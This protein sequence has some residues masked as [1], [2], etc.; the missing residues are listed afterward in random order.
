MGSVSLKLMLLFS[1]CVWVC[2]KG[3]HPGS[4]MLTHSPSEPELIWIPL[5]ASTS[6]GS[7]IIAATT[8]APSRLRLIGPA[9]TVAPRLV[10]EPWRDASSD[11]TTSLPS[12]LLQTLL[13]I[14]FMLWILIYRNVDRARAAWRNRDAH[15]PSRAARRGIGTGT[16]QED[17]TGALA[18]RPGAAGISPA[19]EPDNPARRATAVA[20][21]GEKTSL[22]SVSPCE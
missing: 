15:P 2:V 7:P 17:R 20:R 22:S 1:S 6:V 9:E 8:A 10:P 11:A 12:A 16:L 21:W 5:P 4:L 18:D 3:L 13:K 19:A 14:L